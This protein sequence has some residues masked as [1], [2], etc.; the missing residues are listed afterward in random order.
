MTV[1]G[2]VGSRKPMERNE[3]SHKPKHHHHHQ[4][5]QTM[6]CQAQQRS[7]NTSVRLTFLTLLRLPLLLVVAMS[8]PLGRFSFAAAFLR[9]IHQARRA[10]TVRRGHVLWFRDRDHAP[11]HDKRMRQATTRLF[12]SSSNGLGA[13][14]RVTQTLPPVPPNAH[15]IVACRHGESEFNNANVFTGW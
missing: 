1:K 4:A 15:R 5:T 6:R 11:V 12:Q 2:G 9:S 7:S 3:P 13:A 14:A 10:V 8:S